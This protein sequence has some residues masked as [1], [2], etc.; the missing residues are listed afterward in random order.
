[1]KRYSDLVRQILLKLEARSHD[2][3]YQLLSIDGYS[4][5]EIMYHIKLLY[6]ARLID[7]VDQSSINDMYFFPG[8]LTNE[9]HDY[10]NQIR[11]PVSWEKLKAYLSKEGLD[12]P[13]KLYQL[14]KIWENLI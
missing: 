1:M 12:L 10:L 2:E 8:H 4:E 3:E 14:Y 9:G 7:A 11:P 5:E 6:E 13:L